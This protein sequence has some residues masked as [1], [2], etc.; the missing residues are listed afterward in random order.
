MSDQ[1]TLIKEGLSGAYVIEREIGRGGMATVY[2]ARDVKHDRSVAVKV[3]RP[4]LALAVGAE[5]FTREIK[6]AATLQHPHI[7]PVYDS[8]SV[9]GQLYYVMPFVSGESVAERLGRLGKLSIEE[10]LQIA[11]DVA[12]ALQHAHDEG[13]IHRDIKPAN[14]MLTGGMA[15]V[16]DFGVAVAVSESDGDRLTHTGIA[17]GTPAYMS[18]EQATGESGV[19]GRSDIYS[20]ACVLFEMLAG[21]PPYQ[22]S[23]VQATITQR[24]TDSIPSVRKR[25]AEVPESVDWVIEKAL[26]KMPS[27][28]YQTGAEFARVLDMAKSG[29]T[30]PRVS[31]RKSRLAPVLAVVAI[32]LFGLFWARPW[33]SGGA[34]LPGAA[35][36]AVMPF[37]SSGSGVVLLGEGMVDL[38]STNLDGVDGIRTVDPRAVFDRWRRR[39]DSGPVDRAGALDVGIELGAGAIIQ[40]SVIEAGPEVRI[41]AELVGVDGVQLARVQVDG[42]ADSVLS[43]VDN[44]SVTLLQEVWR[45]QDGVPDLRL[46][47]ITTNSLD[48]IRAYLQGEQHFRRSEWD[49]AV[50]YLERAV[51]T[52]SSF[53]LASFQLTHV[54]GWL[55]GHGSPRALESLALAMRHATRLP[56][57]EQELV[58]T[59]DLF[60]RG[61]PESI[62]MLRAYVRDYPSDAVGWYELG[63]AEYHAQTM[64]GISDVEIY[65]AFERAFD[66]VPTMSAALIHPIE[67]ALVQG[68]RDRF[69]RYISLLDSV[70]GRNDVARFRQIATGLWGSGVEADEA[71]V[72][73]VRSRPEQLDLV[74]QAFF[75]DPDVDVDRILNALDVGIADGGMPAPGLSITKARFLSG[76]GRLEESGALIENVARR[77]PGLVALASVYPVFAGIADAN[78]G[79]PGVAVLNA[80]APGNHL[81]GYL[82]ALYASAM[83]NPLGAS[84][85]LD[86]FAVD[87]T[88]A[89]TGGFGSLITAARGLVVML[90]GDTLN[91]IAMMRAGMEEIGFG[92]GASAF[93]GPARFELG[94][95]LTHNADTRYEGINVLT[96]ALRGEPEYSAIAGLAVARALAEAGE[97]SEAV[98]EYDRFVRLW[99][100]ADPQLQD[101]VGMARRAIQELSGEPAT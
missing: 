7:L 52:D 14:I 9:K 31:A 83:G 89:G 5:R 16:A 78:F 84:A 71:L 26:A 56:R 76:L 10:A 68:D 11:S 3:L 66:L 54:Y 70:G 93:L 63:D 2:L 92:P 43:L 100:G 57:R 67:I 19:D 15:L 53:A 86:Q 79:A 90:E 30:V 13:V 25:R 60:E 21:K 44:L 1:L 38:L 94:L 23:T 8:G 65:A 29:E 91:G 73:L 82:R 39:G 20:L 6:F 88:S 12:N 98:A 75:L 99:E 41:T 95:S 17:I 49:S 47:A 97:N 77:Q 62:E 58:A 40:G 27:D 96:Y 34:V 72:D 61:R 28:R 36:I 69:E 18:P 22:G 74:F 35:V 59:H 87:S 80:S 81:V 42:P 45:S 50:V 37:N 48:A 32:I 101:V 4:E 51:T 33:V 85:E 64:L 46:S 24:F 55:D